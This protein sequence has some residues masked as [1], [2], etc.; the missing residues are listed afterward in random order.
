MNSMFRS[1]VWLL[2]LVIN[3]IDLTFISLICFQSNL[4]NLWIACVYLLFIWAP[5]QLWLLDYLATCNALVTWS[6][7]MTLTSFFVSNQTFNIPILFILWSYRL[8]YSM[9]SGPTYDLLLVGV[10]AVAFCEAEIFKKPLAYS[11]SC[12]TRCSNRWTQ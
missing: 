1:L 9:M 2:K 3:L 10:M 11:K 4:F 7:N 6:W 12:L 5:I 8:F